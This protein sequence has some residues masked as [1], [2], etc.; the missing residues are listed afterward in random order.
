MTQTDP[1]GRHFSIRSAIRWALSLDRQYEIQEWYAI[2]A[3]PEGE[4]LVKHL[5]FEKI[6]GEKRRSETHQGI[7]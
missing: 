5:G 1:Y 2:A 4:K 7:Y 3:T 6:E